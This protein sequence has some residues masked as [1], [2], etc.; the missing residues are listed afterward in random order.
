VIR[1]KIKHLTRFKKGSQVEVLHRGSWRPAE[2]LCGNGRTYA[3][4]YKHCPFLSSPGSSTQEVEYADRVPRK[5][6]RPSPPVKEKA[7][8]WASGDLAEV[9][10]HGSWKPARVI[11]GAYGNEY[12]FV[13]LLDNCREVAVKKLN[14]RKQRVWEN[15]KWITIRKV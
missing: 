2:I 13:L 4:R 12:Y 3:V 6:L 5:A 15:G 8:K 14:L 7:N 10:V 9:L 1:P 11:G